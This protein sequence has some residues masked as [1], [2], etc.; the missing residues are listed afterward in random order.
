MK[1][2][3]LIGCPAK[4]ANLKSSAGEKEGRKEMDVMAHAFNLRQIS[5]SESRLF[6][7]V[8]S[9]TARAMK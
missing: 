9:R 3:D 2:K 8:S 4:L 7:I 1:A 6:Y 5:A